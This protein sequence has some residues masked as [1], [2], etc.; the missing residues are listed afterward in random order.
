MSCEKKHIKTLIERAIKME[1][2]ALKELYHM[3]Y[4]YSK[5]KY[6]IIIGDIYG[7]HYFEDYISKV[8]DEVL[9]SIKK[10]RGSGRKAFCLYV[11]TCI[12]NIAI[13]F[14]R[15]HIKYKYKFISLDEMLDDITVSNY[16]LKNGNI[17]DLVVS[18]IAKYEILFTHILP[19]L[20][21]S[22][23]AAILRKI[24]DVETVEEYAQKV[25][26]VES[27]IRSH[28]SKALKK[29]KEKAATMKLKELYHL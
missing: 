8:I 9:K 13:N 26:C 28:E 23:R 4:E 17:E 12:T 3:F 15:D 11:N 21:N 14:C 16:Y 7:N 22:E 24:K 25:S 27:T 29:M 18:K 1:I 6:Q 5:A 19:E 20:T 2:E 10:F